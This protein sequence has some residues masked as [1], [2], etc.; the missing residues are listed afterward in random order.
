MISSLLDNV[1]F[2]PNMR[3]GIS[4]NVFDTCI[5]YKNT[6]SELM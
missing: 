1:V 6:M 4:D 2:S 5:K 3:D